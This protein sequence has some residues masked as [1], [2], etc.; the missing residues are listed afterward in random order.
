MLSKK[1]TPKRTV[2]KVTFTMPANVAKEQ[3]AIAGDF[4]DWNPAEYVLQKKKDM[5]QIELR[6]KPEQSYRFK[7]LIDNELWENDYAA[8]Q[9]IPNEFGTEDSVVII[10]N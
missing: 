1:F 3:V 8:D 9:Y 5:Y 7:Y 10:G 6:L 2:C 4:N